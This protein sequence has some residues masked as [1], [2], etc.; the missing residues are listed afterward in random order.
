MIEMA[1]LEPSKETEKKLRWSTYVV[2]DDTKFH[3]YIP[4]WR[5]PSPWPGRVFVSMESFTG[6]LEKYINYPQIDSLEDP[7]EAILRPVKEHVKTIR[8]APLGDPNE[9]PTGEPYIPYSLIPQDAVLIRLFV[10]W[11]LHTK[12]QFIDVPTY[13]EDGLG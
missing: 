11:D 6:N 1:L 2:R 9:W 10:A 13:R 4:K 5:V 8:F 12:G 7:I 3:L